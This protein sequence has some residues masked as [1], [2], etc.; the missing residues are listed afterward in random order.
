MSGESNAH[1]ALVLELVNYVRSTHSC[2]GQLALYADHEDVAGGRPERI[3]GFL[4]DVY[5]YDVPTSFVVIGE[6][7]TRR[8]LQSDRSQ[9]QLAAFAHYLSLHE[10]GYLYIF[11]PLLT[12]AAAVDT[13]NSLKQAYPRLHGEVLASE[14]VS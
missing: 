8:D 5:A 13:L 10:V 6:A 7:K 12:C 14:T 2:E 9:K 3:N 11:T 4:P 1:A